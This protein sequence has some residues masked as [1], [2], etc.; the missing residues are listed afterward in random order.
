MSSR[1]NLGK[2]YGATPGRQLS[3][4]FNIPEYVLTEPTF[5]FERLA[6]QMGRC[7]PIKGYTQADGT[8]HTDIDTV[9]YQPGI[10]YMLT[11]YTGN[12]SMHAERTQD[13]S[14]VTFT[15]SD[16]FVSR[17]NYRGPAA[18]GAQVGVTT[19]ASADRITDTGGDAMW[20]RSVPSSLAT[21]ADHGAS[22]S[23]DS[24]AFKAMLN[25][26]FMVTNHTYLLDRVAVSNDLDE[27]DQSLMLTF[28]FDTYN[29]RVPGHLM[30][31]YFCGPASRTSNRPAYSAT[32]PVDYSSE[33]YDIGTGQYCLRIAGTGEAELFER[34]KLDD[35]TTE[36]S[37]HSWRSR[38]TFILDKNGLSRGTSYNLQII[39]HNDRGS[40]CIIITLTDPKTSSPESIATDL[41]SIKDGTSASSGVVYWVPEAAGKPIPAAV[42]CSIRID[43]RRDL[44]GGFSVRKYK[45][46]DTGFFYDDPFACR[47]FPINT[48]SSGGRSDFP[49]VLSWNGKYAVDSSTTID[50]DLLYFDTT[51]QKWKKMTLEY[52]G[53]DYKEYTPIPYVTHYMCRFTLATT[54]SKYSP[55]FISYKVHRKGVTTLTTHGGTQLDLTYPGK[56]KFSVTSQ[57]RFPDNVMIDLTIDDLRG[58]L[59]TLFKTRASISF[60]VETT[61]DPADATKKVVL[62]RGYIQRDD[63]QTKQGTRIWTNHAVHSMKGTGYLSKRLSEGLLNIREGYYDYGDGLPYFVNRAIKEQIGAAGLPNSMVDIPDGTLRLFYG[64]PNTET[65]VEAGTPIDETVK[66]FITDYLAAY[67]WEDVNGGTYGKVRLIEPTT[68]TSVP[69]AYFD[70]GSSAVGPGHMISS[71]YS[72]VETPTAPIIKYTYSEYIKAPEFNQLVVTGLHILHGSNTNQKLT[73]IF[74]NFKSADFGNGLVDPSHP[75]YLGRIVTAIVSLPTTLHFSDPGGAIN[76]IGRRIHYIGSHARK[77]VTFQAP[78]LFIDSEFYAEEHAAGEATREK[79]PLKFQ[80]VV[81]VNGTNMLI[82]EVNPVIAKAFNQMCMYTCMVPLDVKR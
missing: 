55:K 2:N 59:A 26:P 15:V 20:C 39:K 27:V 16:Q 24:T 33:D 13:T 49:F 61:Y 78:L 80:D 57:K 51:A 12:R 3:F 53:A 37:A 67:L 72:G 43:M 74:H 75:D 30:D 65:F 9:A 77:Y 36:N 71:Y 66:R 10:G 1:A 82:V 29:K 22:M 70:D 32:T 44:I 76:F 54:N 50:G 46:Y 8:I 35:D 4:S 14:L 11:A 5:S 79:R 18:T 21:W 40:R 25:R 63:I 73:Q 42:Q 69:V 17:N 56:C 34:T 81:N 62:A 38:R 7:T 31:F 28:H 52:T 23:A 19:G 60:M 41:V 6:S 64:D 58:E 68:D 45:F 48:D 47:F